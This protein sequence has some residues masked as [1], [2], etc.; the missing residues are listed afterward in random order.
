MTRPRTS[1]LALVAL[2]VV[3]VV[4]AGAVVLLGRSDDP[5]GRTVVTVRLWDQ[6]VAAAYRESFAE[7]SRSRPDIEV[8]TTLVSYASYF[9]TLRTDVAGGGADDVFWINNSHFAEYADNGR[10]MPVTPSADWEPSVVG[11]FTRGG[12]LW[13]VPQLTDAGIAL[14]YN[15]E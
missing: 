1:T 3:A 11:Q 2:L 4:L 9:D 12:T 5:A 14:Y 10:L 13:G 15:A 7:F 8:R 6:Q